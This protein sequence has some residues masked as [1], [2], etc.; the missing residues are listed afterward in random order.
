MGSE[1][2]IRDSSLLAAQILYRINDELHINLSMRQLLDSGTVAEV[3]TL[4]EQNHVE[5]AESAE[6]TDILAELEGLSDEAVQQLLADDA[7]ESPEVKAQPIPVISAVDDSTDD[8]ALYMRMVI[9]KAKEAIQLNQNPVAACIVK[10]GQV[11]TCVHNAVLQ[12][13]DVTAHAEMLAIREA[14]HQLDTL[15]LSGCVLYC[16]LE[17]CPMC[18]SASH[19]ANLDKIVYGC[20]LYTS[21]SPRDLSTSRMPSSA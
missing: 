13:R 11:I 7:A 4:I 17:P 20:L 18:F 5:Q 8:Y 14:C 12:N 10:E 16:T 15:D 2:C 3:S 21:P 1:M 19:W 9:E 6:I